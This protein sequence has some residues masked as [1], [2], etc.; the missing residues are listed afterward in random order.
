[1]THTTYAL[2]GTDG[3]NITGVTLYE[4]C[5]ALHAAA[6]EKKLYAGAHVRRNGRAVA[7]WCAYQHRVRPMFS[8]NT[9]EA[10]DII[11]DIVP[12]LA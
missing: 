3:R 6:S 10:K 8:A 9:I 2:V 7:F 12:L 1:M 5:K 11:T 4:A